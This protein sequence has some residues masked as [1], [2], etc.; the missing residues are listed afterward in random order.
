MSPDVFNITLPSASYELYRNFSDALNGIDTLDVLLCDEG[1]R[2]K[3]A[4]GTKT[5][6]ALCNC[7]AIRRL[8]LTG[9]PVQNNLDELYAMVHFAVPWFLGT[10]QDFKERY[11]DPITLH[12]QRQTSGR[13]KAM[14]ELR[15]KLQLILIRRTR[16]EIMHA[17]LPARRELI[18]RIALSPCQYEEYIGETRGLLAHLASTESA[19]PQSDAS[20]LPKLLKLRILCTRSAV[21]SSESEI[22][23]IPG[24]SITTIGAASSIE[25]GNYQH[26]QLLSRSQKFV[27]LETLL[28]TIKS[29]SP[30]DK[31]IVASNFIE[32]LDCCKVLTMIL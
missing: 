9:T 3:N 11:S 16:E 20:I 30:G 24:S 13:C 2:L 4:Y 28:S 18:L 6:T 15:E 1:H 10:L 22:T 7:G 21:P 12:Q 5:S 25:S 32:N 19:S 14:D 29:T 23:S 31:V 17:I 27:V 8:V 26:Q